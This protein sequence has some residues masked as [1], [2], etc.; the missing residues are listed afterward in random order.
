MNTKELITNQE[1]VN[2]LVSSL[3]DFPQGSDTKYDL[4]IIQN[5][6]EDV[7]VSEYFIYEFDSHEEAV[8]K[9]ESIDLKFIEELLEHP[10]VLC[11][12][13]KYNDYFSVEIEEV[14][15]D[16]EDEN[17]TINI[18][19]IYTRDI[20]LTDTPK[21]T[22][23]DGDPIIAVSTG[24][25]EFLEDNTLKIRTELLHG[26]NLNELVNIYFADDKD[27]DILSCK[28]ISCEDAYYFCELNL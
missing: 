27:S 20:L 5:N 22:G 6:Y 4:W 23:L 8:T 13:G 19:T 15:V 2:E 1:L 26:F 14:I 21:E 17:N 12:D 9:A 16:P 24:D 7:E 10:V 3:E 25:Y 28:I 11:P 18:G